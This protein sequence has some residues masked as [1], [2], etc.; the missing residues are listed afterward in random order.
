MPRA[1]NAGATK[2][3]L[4]QRGGPF[5]STKR[6]GAAPGAM[7]AARR[8]TTGCDGA[9]MVALVFGA[10]FFAF[11]ASAVAGD[12]AGLV[13]VPVLRGRADRGRA[14]RVGDR[15]GGQRRVAHRDIAPLDPPGCGAA[16]RA[17]RA[18]R[19]VAAQ[20][21]RAGPYRIHRRLLPARQP[22]RAVPPPGAGGA[23]AAV[24]ARAAADRRGRVPACRSWR[25]GC[26]G[27]G[28]VPA[29]GRSDRAAASRLG[30]ARRPRQG[31]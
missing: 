9:A 8:A 6:P 28:D 24:V 25:D 27:R 15:Q 17:R 21:D 10:A 29:A 7:R 23:A 4:R 19:R 16:L 12:G 14:R 13:L 26:G 3:P 2:G 18:A 22:S 1:A 20:P 31:T 11:L 30:D 5:R